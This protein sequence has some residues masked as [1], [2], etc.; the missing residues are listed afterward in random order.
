MYDFSVVQVSQGDARRDKRTEGR[1]PLL[2]VIEGLD[3][4]GKTTFAAELS[5]VLNAPVL[6]LDAAESHNDYIDDMI[7]A[8][9]IGMSAP[10]RDIILDRSIF[11]G[12]CYGEIGMMRKQ[13]LFARWLDSLNGVPVFVIHLVAEESVRMARDPRGTKGTRHV[14]IDSEMPTLIQD[15][16]RKGSAIEYRIYDTG[17]LQPGH[18]IDDIFRVKE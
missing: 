2:Y 13:M 3:G 14:R 11:S 17:R 10:T 5:H 7:I 1:T 12:L 9:A 6:K 18:I 16:Q 8:R 15:A 4:T